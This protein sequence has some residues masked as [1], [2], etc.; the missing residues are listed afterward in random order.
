MRLLVVVLL[1]ALCSPASGQ[2]PVRLGDRVRIQAPRAGYRNLVGEVTATTPDVVSVKSR[3]YVDDVAVRRADI[4]NIQRSIGSRTNVSRGVVI[5]GS[6]GLFSALWFAQSP[7]PPGSSSL[8]GRKTF[9]AKN[10]AIGGIV[11]AGL[12]AMVGALVRSDTWIPVSA[13][14]SAGA[15]TPALGF[16]IRF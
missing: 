2:R 15:T 14:V 13:A 11:G 16:S 10:T 1:V 8:D 9:S 6:L 12:G 3:E 7:P 5:G 4:V